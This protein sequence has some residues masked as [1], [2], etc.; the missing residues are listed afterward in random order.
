MYLSKL[1]LRENLERAKPEGFFF[2]QRGGRELFHFCFGRPE[3]IPLEMTKPNY[4][5][6]FCVMRV[7]C[8]T[9]DK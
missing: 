3:Y 1:K 7:L 9:N 5:L 6:F 2:N 8:T 4:V